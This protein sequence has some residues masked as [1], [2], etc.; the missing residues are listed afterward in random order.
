MPPIVGFDQCENAPM[1][2]CGMALASAPLMVSKIRICRIG[3]PPEGAGNFGLK[4]E[5]SR[6]F[7]LIGR[8]LPSVCGSSALQNALIANTA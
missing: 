2:R 7:S 1:A 4:N 6:T 8:M 3:R 5:P